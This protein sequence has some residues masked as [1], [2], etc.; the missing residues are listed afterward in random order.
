[1]KEKVKKEDIAEFN[2]DSNIFTMLMLVTIILPVPLAKIAG[3]IG[4]GIWAVI[5]GITFF[6]ALRVEKKKKSFDVQTY[7]E[8]LAFTEGTNL[9]EM[10]KHQ[11]YG[12]R[13]YQKLLLAVGAG[14][15]A[16][17]VSTFMIWIM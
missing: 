17:A 5:A 10:E 1:M 4:F 12:K 7:K 11:E 9:N 14:L 6:Y 8:I 13:P 16:L 3:A 15:I 2:R